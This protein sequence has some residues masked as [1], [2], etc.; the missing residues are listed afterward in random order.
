LTILVLN[1]WLFM[2]II[3]L[4][5]Q[6]RVTTSLNYVQKDRP[7][8]LSFS[9]LIVTGWTTS[10][11]HPR[12]DC[13]YC[14]IAYALLTNA[15]EFYE[16]FFAR[17]IYFL[18]YWLITL[19]EFTYF[20]V[21]SLRAKASIF[22]C[23]Y[24][25]AFFVAGKTYF[26]LLCR[27]GLDFGILSLDCKFFDLLVNYSILLDCLFKFSSILFFVIF[28]LEHISS[29]VINLLWLFTFEIFSLVCLFDE[30]S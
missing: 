17:W 30:P 20:F 8:V 12:M 4:S 28:A 13:I 26:L 5:I 7:R 1:L 2:R 9:P 22:Q 15:F 16:Q 29:L 24:R 18:S 11:S 3:I 14:S 23:S 21:A 25:K 19:I 27:C 6:M 10:A